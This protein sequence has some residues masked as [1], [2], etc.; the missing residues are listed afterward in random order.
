MINMP[1]VSAI[2]IFRNEEKF[3]SEAIESVLWQTYPSWELL[4]VDDGSTDASTGIAIQYSQQYPDRV[5]YLEHEGHSNRGMSASRN[6]GIQHAKGDYIAFLDGDDVWLANKLQRQLA[7]MEEQPEAVMVYGTTELWHGWTGKSE[8]ILRDKKQPIAVEPDTLVRPPKLFTMFLARQAITPCP[9][10]VLLRRQA[11]TAVGG[12]EDSFAGMYEDHVFYSKITLQAPV[13]V[14]GECWSRHRQH[15]DSSCSVWRRTGEYYS[16]KPNIAFLAWT[17]E[18]LHSLGIKDGK[19]ESI[20]RKRLWRYRH[21]VL[22]RVFRKV[23]YIAGSIW[24]SSV[25][26]IAQWKPD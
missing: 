23:R 14:A 20:L 17:R 9:S 24:S 8:D 16:A 18:Y 4:L 2:I 21:P 13:F 19:L 1:L 26:K 7:I 11:V 25:S 12:F 22:F 3:L 10:D 6:L 15:P 5:R